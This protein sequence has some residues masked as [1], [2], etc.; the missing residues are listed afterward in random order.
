MPQYAQVNDLKLAYRETGRG[1]AVVFVNGVLGSL[2]GWKPQMSLLAG[3]HRCIAYD[4]RGQSLSDMGAVEE[5]SIDHHA[6]DMAGLLDALGERRAHFVGLSYGASLALYFAARY[7]ERVRSVSLIGAIGCTDARQQAVFQSWLDAAT[8]AP[9]DIYRVSA[10][11]VYSR[12]F[13]EQSARYLSRVERWMEQAGEAY[14]EGLRRLLPA[15]RDIDILA[16]LPRIR[17]PVLTIMGGED[18]LVTSADSLQI[19]DNVPDLEALLVP[20]VGHIV[21]SEKPGEVG[22]ALLGFIGKHTA[23]LGA[24]ET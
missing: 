15:L 9:G 6:A 10:P 13:R 5:F 17:C 3:N 11:S 23:A 21:N 24:A 16:H 7:P 12:R 22:T 1:E 4:M 8:H 2:R 18:R 14:F 20:D 19:L